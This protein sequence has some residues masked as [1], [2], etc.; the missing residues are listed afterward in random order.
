MSSWKREPH[1]DGRSLSYWLD[2]FKR[3]SIIH[4]EAEILLKE[5]QSKQSREAI[6]AIGTNALP[7]LL[8]WIAYEPSAPKTRV[9]RVVC[10]IV[11]E[12]NYTRP[13]LMSLFRRDLQAADAVAGFLILGESAVP[14]I[15]DLVKLATD[16]QRNK[17]SDRAT[18]ALRYIG[19][20]SQEALASIIATRS[21]PKPD[22]A[23]ALMT[24]FGTNSRRAVPIFLDRLVDRDMDF[25]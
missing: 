4:N 15:P 2:L 21:P 24:K 11:P 7:C 10:R 18:L 13:F 22:D 6:R 14:A 17:S 19:P 16:P 12:N 20:K 23:T 9:L 1:Y 25:Q 3:S 8:E 5:D